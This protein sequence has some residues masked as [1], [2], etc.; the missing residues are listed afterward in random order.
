MQI[1]M[2]YYGTY[3]LAR[4]AGLTKEAS[5][6]IATASQ[7]VD[8]NGQQGG[9]TL[10]DALR[11][12]VEATAF[13]TTAL[14]NLSP[15]AQRTVWLPFHFLPGN[16]GDT[17]TARLVCRKNSLISQ[18][19]RDHHSNQIDKPYFLELVGVMAH[20]YADTFAHYGFSGV[21]SRKNRVDRDSF[22]FG[23]L[24]N[25]VKDYIEKKKTSFFKKFG[26]GLIENIMG[27]AAQNISGA[28]GHA[29]VVTFPDRPFL[30]WRFD[31]E[32]QGDSGW[33]E[34][35]KTYL[36]YAFYIHEVFCQ[37]AKD[38]PDLQDTNQAQNWQELSPKIE[39]VL[40]VQGGKEVRIQAWKEA[41]L[42]DLFNTPEAIPTYKNWNDGFDTLGQKSS[43]EAM[44][45]PIFHFYQVASYHRWYVL[46]ELLPSHGLMVI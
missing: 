27:D 9:I 6:I 46:R 22:E 45:H 39:S 36:E 33:R 19:L 40:M 10:K 18:Q 5:R 21:S 11:C 38:R 44:S 29:G 15:D 42:Q 7:F 20:V 8:D 31:Y 14:R 1:C 41:S 23:E 17:F 28:L 30:K 34:N 43:E 24:N 12:V 37:I 26:E 32:F 2:H 25:N 4:S 16:E 35:T 13:H 3:C